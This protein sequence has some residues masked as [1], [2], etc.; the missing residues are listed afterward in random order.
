MIKNDDRK[1]NSQTKYKNIYQTKLQNFSN[2]FLP[3]TK[4][5]FTEKLV[6]NKI[7]RTL[8]NKKQRNKNERYIFV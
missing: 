2:R 4:V 3:Y 5:E 8:M 7:L 6:L 1:I